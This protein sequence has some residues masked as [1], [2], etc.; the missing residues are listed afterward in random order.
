M[1]SDIIKPEKFDHFCLVCNSTV[2]LKHNLFYDS[3]NKLTLQFLKE[4]KK[5]KPAPIHITN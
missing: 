3:H 1:T 4:G 5:F 2:P